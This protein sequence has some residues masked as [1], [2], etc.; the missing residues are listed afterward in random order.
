[1]GN[2][3]EDG[4]AVDLDYTRSGLII[5]ADHGVGETGRIGIAVNYQLAELEQE[6]RRSEGDVDT[7]GVSIYGGVRAGAL[8]LSGE[9]GHSWRDISTTRQVTVGLIDETL[10]ASYDAQASHVQVRIGAPMGDGPT[11]IEPFL[12]LAYVNVE[13]DGFTE[14]GGTAALTRDDDSDSVVF[15]TA[16]LRLMSEFGPEGRDGGIYGVLG[17]RHAE[18]D[19]LPE[20][21]VAFASNPGVTFVTAGAP[22]AEDS[23]ALEAGLRLM[24][25]PRTSL[26]A[27]YRGD[28]ADEAQDHA[29]SLRLAFTH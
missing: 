14:T 3:E 8:A 13:T 27:S 29:A 1:M 5:G 11:T 19:I 9:A 16:G 24:L 25:G 4:N 21:E 26:T 18:G 15:S 23:L 6:P 12:A 28:I 7:L 22:I 17:W 10:R 2:V 20:Q